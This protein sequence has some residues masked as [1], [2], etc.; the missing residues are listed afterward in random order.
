MKRTLIQNDQ[1]FM[2][3]NEEYNN[4]IIPSKRTEMW[5]DIDLKGNVQINGGIFGKSLKLDPDFVFIRDSVFILEQIEIIGANKGIAWF[6]SIVNAEHSLQVENKNSFSRFGA[7]LRAPHIN[8]E[9]VVVYGNV[10]CK[11]AIIKNSIIF[12]IVFADNE[13]I[14]EN[15]ILGSFQTNTL[16]IKKNT[17]LIFPFVISTN[18]PEIESNT[19]Y[20]LVSSISSGKPEL[21]IIPHHKEDIHRIRSVEKGIHH[22][23]F[24]PTMRIFDLKPFY[25]QVQMNIIKFFQILEKNEGSIKSKDQ[26][27]SEF[28]TPFFNLIKNNFEIKEVQGKSN[29]MNLPDS[30][31]K[32]LTLTTVEDLKIEEIKE[33]NEI[34]ED[35]LSK[36]ES[37]EE[38]HD[39]KEELMSI[40]EG[41]DIKLETKEESPNIS[42]KESETTSEITK[43]NE[44][45]CP[46]CG[47]VIDNFDYIFCENCGYKLKN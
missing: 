27:L 45:V 15:T 39:Q 46:K 3:Q 42:D 26:K 9:N 14:I 30:V 38:S 34:V 32:N 35:T 8:I 43:D 16:K 41:K 13:L 17:G 2:L 36:L 20:L 19:Y 28:E 11:N 12:G 5:R 37:V 1:M 40:H 21:N 18:Y 44:K 6:N 10:F 22:Y 47:H 33:K 25:E 4:N 29:F 24:S 31:L 23:I 7:D